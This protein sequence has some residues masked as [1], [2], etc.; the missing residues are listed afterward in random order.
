MILELSFCTRTLSFHCM[1]H[2]SVVKLLLFKFGMSFIQPTVKVT[3]FLYCWPISK[4]NLI[5]FHF[6]VCLNYQIH[7][8]WDVCC[9]YCNWGL[10]EL[11][12]CLWCLGLCSAGRQQKHVVR[13]S[14]AVNTELRTFPFTARAT[15]ASVSSRS[16][17]SQRSPSSLTQALSHHLYQ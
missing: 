13:K 1:S 10:V 15:V 17:S 8:F 3:F 12:L 16:T 5:T 4:V 11:Y 6:K 14:R 9:N 7:H 2:S